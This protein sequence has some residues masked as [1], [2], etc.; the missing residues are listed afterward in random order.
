MQGARTPKLASPSDISPHRKAMLRS[1]DLALEISRGRAPCR[2][3]QRLTRHAMPDRVDAPLR[4]LSAP[5][6]YQQLRVPDDA[7][8]PCRQGH[9]KADPR[10][11]A[12][13]NGVLT[14]RPPC[15]KGPR[16]TG[17]VAPLVTD[18]GVAMP[19]FPPPP[20]NAPM[21]PGASSVRHTRAVLDARLMRLF[22]A[23]PLVRRSGLSVLARPFDFIQATSL[24]SAGLAEIRCL[25]RWP[26]SPCRSCRVSIRSVGWTAPSM[27]SSDF[28]S[29]RRGSIHCPLESGPPTSAIRFGGTSMGARNFPIL[30]FPSPIVLSSGMTAPTG[31]FMAAR[32]FSPDSASRSILDIPKRA[33]PAR[34]K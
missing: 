4:M 6:A 25:L 7:R 3:W 15:P 11:N 9:G 19:S 10:A 8:M 5:R 22:S 31:C 27:T 14:S 12:L 24:T 34:P 13:A 18:P 29:S 17:L 30:R 21:T 28:R 26:I 16:R 33:S 23:V 2:T 20:S 1:A 32:C